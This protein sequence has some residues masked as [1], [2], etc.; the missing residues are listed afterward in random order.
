MFEDISERDQLEHFQRA[1]KDATGEWLRRVCKS[2][3]PDYICAR[4]DGALVGIEFTLIT[5]K[6]NESILENILDDAEYMNGL[7]GVDAVANAILRK[8][9]KRREADWKLPDSSILVL[10]T[11]DCPISEMED[12]LCLDLQPEFAESGFSEIWIADHTETDAY[13]TI[14]LFGLVPRKWWGYHPAPWA[15]KPYG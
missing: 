7:D 1:Y 3:R 11:P 6:Q 15:G 12:H 9:R 10:S 8:A 14:D 4:P 13:G 2:E 5:R